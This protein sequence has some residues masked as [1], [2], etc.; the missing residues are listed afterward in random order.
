MLGLLHSPSLNVFEEA[1]FAARLH[2]MS[3][4]TGLRLATLGGAQ[5]LRIEGETGSLE[6]GKWADLAV[7]GALPGGGEPEMEVLEAAAEGGVEGTV[8]GG[9]FVYG[10]AGA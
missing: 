5:A 3:G 8:V 1:L 6:V 7:V 10:G 2:G 9:R 4:A